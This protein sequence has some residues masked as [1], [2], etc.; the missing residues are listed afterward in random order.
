[1]NRSN[2]FQTLGN[3]ELLSQKKI[4]I[5]ASKNA[6]EELLQSKN[7]LF[8]KLLN[9]PIALAG[10]WQSPMEKSIYNCFDTNSAANIIHYIAKDINQFIPSKKQQNLIDQNKLLIVSPELKEV[11]ASAPAVDKRDRLIFS[12]NKSI[13]FLYIEQGGRL[14]KYFRELNQLNYQLFILDQ[15]SNDAYFHDDIIRIDEDSVTSMI[16]L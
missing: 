14:E 2:I 7:E 10:G 12:Q 13:F 3:V 1:M 15:P 6:P 16:L 5:F 4:A 11:R 8:D 9:M